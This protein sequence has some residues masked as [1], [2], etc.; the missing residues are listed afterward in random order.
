MAGGHDAFSISHPCGEVQ[1]LQDRAI[2]L[3]KRHVHVGER[4]WIAERMLHSRT[5]PTTRMG[6]PDVWFPHLHGSPSIMWSRVGKMHG[7]QRL[8]LY[9]ERRFASRILTVKTLGASVSLV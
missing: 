6:C 4:P 2:V 7:L 1:T 9:V 5:M 3:S 8:T